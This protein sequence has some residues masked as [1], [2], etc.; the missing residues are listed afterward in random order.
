M[1]TIALLLSILLFSCEDGGIGPNYG[2]TNLDAVNYDPNANIDDASCILP[3]N[4]TLNY[5][6]YFQNIFSSECFVCHFNGANYSVEDLE[7]IGWLT[8][9]DASTSEL[10]TRIT[11]P[12]SNVLSMPQ[13]LPPLGTVTII[14]I[15]E[16]IN[17]GCP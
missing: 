16:W 3:D 14:Q 11:L 4:S 8:P 6:S 15:E 2:C 5:T 12:E 7:N 9:G 13:N 10:Y 17:N 1:K